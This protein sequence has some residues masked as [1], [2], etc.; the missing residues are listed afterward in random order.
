MSKDNVPEKIG[1]KDF[2]TLQVYKKSMDLAK[3]VYDVAEGLPSSEKYAMSSQMKRAVTS[4]SANIAEGQSNLYIKK[5]MTFISTALGS[6]GEMRCWYEHCVKL[7]YITVE[8]YN[9][10]DA[11]TVEIIKMLHGYAKKLRREITNT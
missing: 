8:Q 1:I 7:G 6:C 10:L 3:N 4:I 9:K 2:K 11:D 5:E